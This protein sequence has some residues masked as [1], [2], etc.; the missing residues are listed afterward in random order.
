MPVRDERWLQ[1]RHRCWY[2]VREIPKALRSHFGGKRRLI[3]SLK[4][5]NLTLAQARRH[6]VLAEW[7]KQF[8]AARAP[9]SHND[10][11]SAALMW[12][13]H[14]AAQ[15]IEEDA[16][17]AQWDI[18]TSAA[19]IADP[20]QRSTFL[21]IATGQHTPVEPFVEPWLAEQD[22]SPTSKEAHR[23]SLKEL[24]EWCEHERVPPTVEGFN[25]RTAGA[26]VSHLL[27]RGLDRSRTVAT[28]LWSL[29]SFWS[30][31]ESKGYAD[32]NIWR[33]HNTGGG[34]SARTK[35]PERPF[36]AAELR[37]L[38]NGSP[39]QP[40]A[41]LMRLGLLSGARLEEL[42]LLR[43]RDI[44]VTEHTMALVTNPKTPSSRR[45]VPVHSSAWS[46]IQ[47]RAEGKG[48]D[49][50]LFHEL[51]DKDGG[52]RGNSMSQA[53]TRFRRKAGVNDAA[54]GQRR[55]LVN[56]HSFRRTFVTLA[57]QAGQPES[58]IRAVVGHKRAGMTFGIYSGGPS[59]EQRRMCVERVRLPT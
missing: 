49:D 52:R 47:A 29:S 41:D 18:E 2:V 24:L 44:D 54:E 17:V 48:T 4:T 31:L 8:D 20:E 25:R 27:G 38:F 55:G 30:W 59:L 13:E 12:R 51:P 40:L 56:F 36:T 14:A 21:A 58:T 45:V 46:T 16:S 22:V 1:M 53:F 15:V 23:R 33:G 19:D 57:E 10:M 5:D 9:K 43:V 35:Q 26:Y 32:S 11:V 34:R 42:V 37:Q 39:G 7:Q 50:F 3:Q 6:R 28:R